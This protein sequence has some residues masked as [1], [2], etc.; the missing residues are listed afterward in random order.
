M[1]LLCVR[2]HKK[3][4]KK[5]NSDMNKIIPLFLLIFC[6]SCLSN[7]S[8][9]NTNPNISLLSEIEVKDFLEPSNLK[10]NV[11][12]INEYVY[13]ATLNSGNLIKGEESKRYFSTK[14]PINCNIDIN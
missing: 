8:K 12:S 9:T 3:Q 13:N 2:H 4:N 1:T 5:M 11:K 6:L 7:K 10:G 14:Q